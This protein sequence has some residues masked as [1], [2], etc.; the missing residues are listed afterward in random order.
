MT[1]YQTATTRANMM[2][3]LTALIWGFAFVAQRISID[4]IGP[5]L[6]NAIRFA[7]GS[8]SLIP[9]IAYRRKR[10]TDPAQHLPLKSYIVPGL[11]AGSILFLGAS[12]QQVGIVYTDAGKAGF[13]TGLYVVLVPVIGI[14]WGHKTTWAVWIGVVLAVTGLYL[15][16]VTGKLTDIVMG[17]VLVL[18]GAFFWANHV[19]VIA[20]LS[21]KMD[22]VTLSAAQFAVV[23]AYSYAA[24]FFNHESYSAIS[25]AGAI[26]PLLYGGFMSVGIAYTLQVVAQKTAHPAYVSIILSLETVFAAIGGWLILDEQFTPRTL[27]GCAVMLT[28]IIAAQIPEIREGIK[29]NRTRPGRL[30]SV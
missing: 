1:Q 23:S 21:P 6:F 30:S 20:K 29:Q 5:F 25:M 17:D 9:L 3:L 14:L 15:L 2:M 27:T 28:G 18:I 16:S 24:S 8:L 10:L 12:F 7:L 4:F 19:L 11:T 26:W 13:I 22:P